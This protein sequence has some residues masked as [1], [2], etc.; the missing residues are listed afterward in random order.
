VLCGSFGILITLAVIPG[1]HY[2]THLLEEVSCKQVSKSGASILNLFSRFYAFGLFLQEP[3]RTDGGQ[4]TEG[5]MMK[6]MN[7]WSPSMS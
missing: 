6:A 5:E 4:E 1:Q 3:E 7:F 2:H